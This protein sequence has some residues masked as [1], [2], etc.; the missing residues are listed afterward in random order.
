MNWPICGLCENQ[1][2]IRVDDGKGG[3]RPG[4]LC[5]TCQDLVVTN[6]GSFAGVVDQATLRKISLEIQEKEKNGRD[7]R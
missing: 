3:S 2:V 5:R 7:T 4:Y 1:N 6:S